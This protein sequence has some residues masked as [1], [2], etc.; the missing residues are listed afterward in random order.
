[1]KLMSSSLW[2]MILTL[3]LLTVFAPACAPNEPP[4]PTK[5]LQHLVLLTDVKQWNGGSLITYLDSLKNEDYR[6]IISG[7]AGETADQLT[8]R[9]PWLLQPGVDMFLYDEKLAGTVGYDSLVNYLH[10]NKLET[11]V[12]AISKVR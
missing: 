7:Y 1:M 11:R 3:L 4:P 5:K 8:S 12:K 10:R 9:L 2:V 6:V